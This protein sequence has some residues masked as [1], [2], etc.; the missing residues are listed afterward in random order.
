MEWEKMCANHISDRRLIF[1]ICKVLLQPK[2]NN[3]PILKC[4]KDMNRLFFKGHEIA[5][6]KMFNVTNHQGNSS[7]THNEV[8]PHTC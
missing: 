7:Q 5:K 2:A 1:Q 8:S 6:E 3:N 4:T